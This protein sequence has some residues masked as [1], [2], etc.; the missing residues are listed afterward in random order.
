MARADHEVLPGPRSFN[1]GNREGTERLHPGALGRRLPYVVFADQRVAVGG[2]RALLLGWLI[3]ILVIAMSLPL[4]RPVNDD[5]WALGS[6]MS[7]GFLRSLAWYY[8]DFQ[9]NVSSW[10][11][12]LLHQLPWLDGVPPWASAL[13]IATTLVLLAAAAWGALSFLGL[14]WPSGW[15]FWAI[16]TMVTVVAWLSLASLISPNGMTLVFYVPS[17]IV[18]VWPWCC[19]LFALGLATHKTAHRGALLC[20]GLLGFMAGNLGFVEGVIIGLSTAIVAFFAWRRAT[21]W[22]ISRPLAWSWLLGLAFGLGVQI[23]SPATWGRGSGVGSDW[24]LS[25][26]VD[27]I[28][29][30]FSQADILTGTSIAQSLLGIADVES[31]ARLLVPIAVL[32]DLVFRVGLLAVFLLAAWWASRRP[33]DFSLSSNSL[34]S[35][36]LGLTLVSLVGAAA[37]SV[38]GAL[39]AY[40]GRHVAGLAVVVTV[41]LAGLGVLSRPWWARHARLLSVGFVLSLVV[42]TGLGLQQVIYG[43]SRATDWDGALKVN[44][45]LIVQGRLNE[46]VDVPLKAGLSQS[47]LRDHDGSSAYVEWV[48]KQLGP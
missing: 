13:S 3:A 17:T 45:M 15:R 43:W 12:I 28:N 18:H 37:Y 25:T 1:E 47:G 40:A 22:S 35:R 31:W 32:G 7:R 21:E 34:R 10:F 24:A 30:L 11:F 27:A 42:L 5:Y 6:L 14:V 23:A 29:R 8:T 46:L 44:R 2:T 39:Y 33:T 26:N 41:I 19:A 4:G 38:S 16:L 20:V 9:G 48:R 36:L